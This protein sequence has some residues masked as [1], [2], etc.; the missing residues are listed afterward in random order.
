M[1]EKKKAQLALVRQLADQGRVEILA[2]F[3][4]RE[5]VKIAADFVGGAGEVVQRALASSAPA[6]MICG[7]SYMIAEIERGQPRA[8]LL[9]PRRDLACPLAEAVSRAQVEDAKKSHPRALVVTDIKVAPELRDLADL[10]ISPLT[11]RETLKALEGRELI[12]LPGAHLADLAEFGSQVVNRWPE[13]V[14]QVHELALPEE[15]VAAQG[16][17]PEAKTAVH[18]LCRQ[19]LWA[20][21]D[22]V[23]DSA[24]IYHFCQT[25]QADEFIIV[26]EAGLAEY[27]TAAL[28]SKT[29][30]E[31]EAEIYC[32]NMKLTNLKSMVDSLEKYL[33]QGSV[34]K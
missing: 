21:A 12:L 3:F 33:A 4:Q 30:Y 7:A 16:Q 9:V 18:L 5:E 32:P 15:L 17:H 11:A 10:E 8:H 31:T 2:H 34:T 23:G 24:G 29:F 13:A 14:C 1:N 22:Y 26:S 25:S 20:K 28:P 27:L 6:V 19:E